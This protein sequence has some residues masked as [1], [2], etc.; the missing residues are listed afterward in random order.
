LAEPVIA[1]LREQRRDQSVDA[2]AP[3]ILFVLGDTHR[4]AVDAAD[5][6]LVVNGG[7]IGAGGTGNLNEGQDASLAVVTY[8]RG[9]FVPL[10]ADLVTLD[11]GTGETVARRVRIDRK[12]PLQV[13]D[14]AVPGG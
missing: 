9:P 13:G 14:P 3:S 8:E 6:V 10:A 2:E 11:P 5:G 7:T 4:P 1:Q 12:T